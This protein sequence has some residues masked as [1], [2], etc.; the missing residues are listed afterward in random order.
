MP[1]VRTTASPEGGKE[2]KKDQGEK[3]DAPQTPVAR[4][5]AS[6]EGGERE[7][8][9]QEE[10]KEDGANGNG[11]RR[12]MQVP[13]TRKRKMRDLSGATEL[14]EIVVPWYLCKQRQH[15]APVD[16]WMVDLHR[17]TL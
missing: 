11:H 1:V 7:V 3:D 2:E 9:G 15:A 4:T 17:L 13:K 5:T 12:E 10:Q 14:D 6:S 8:K 16:T